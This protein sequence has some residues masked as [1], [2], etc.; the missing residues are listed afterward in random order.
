MMNRFIKAGAVIIAA[1]AMSLAMGVMAL[2]AEKGQINVTGKGI[3]TVEPDLATMYISI[4][5]NAPTAEEAQKQN[6]D[7]SGSVISGLKAVGIKDEDI[8]TNRYG[9]YPRY[10]YDEKTG[11]RTMVGY[12]V[13]NNLL[14]TTA[15]VKNT[16][17]YLDAA[18]KAGA[19]GNDNVEFSVKDPTQHYAQALSLA[20]QNANSSAQTIAKALGVVQGK[21]VRV[22]ENYSSDSYLRN[23]SEKASA[24]RDMGAGSAADIR[25][26][27]IQIS[28]NVNVTYLFE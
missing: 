18:V 14:V 7:K 12:E 3:V 27:K 24:V 19:T 4:D 10:K 28:A 16:G 2:A 22:D 20:I 1:G 5:T 21:A 23:E 8:K 26:D 13:S 6:A 9:V 11:E 25:Y 17:K 15:D